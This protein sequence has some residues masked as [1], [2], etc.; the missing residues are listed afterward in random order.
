MNRRQYAIVALFSISLLAV[1]L[2]P[3]SGQQGSGYDP[4]LDYNDDGIINVEDLHALGQAYG[5]SG[6]PLNLPMALEYDSGWLEI[7]DKQGQ[8]TTITPNV[9]NLET[10]T[11]VPC[12]Y[13]KTLLESPVHQRYFGVAGYAYGWIRYYGGTQDG[14]FESVVQTSDFGYALAGYTKSYGPTGDFWLVK[15]DASGNMEWNKTYGWDTE[16][17]DEHAY[18]VI[19]TNDGGYALAGCAL[20]GCFWLVK[21]D[22]SGNMQWNRTYERDY[23][24]IFR[25]LIQTSDGGYILAGWG[26]AWNEDPPGI[27]DDFWLVKTDSYGNME[28]NRTGANG[29]GY[30]VI[31]TNDGGYALAGSKVSASG[32]FWLVKTD[33][34]GNE[35][36]NKTLGGTSAYSVIQTGDGGYA[37][38]GDS[39]GAISLIITDSSGNKQWGGN[40]GSG[41]GYSVV[42]T[43]DRGYALAGYGYTSGSAFILVKTDYKATMQWK[44]TYGGAGMKAHS[45]VQTPDGGY[46]L[47]GE[48]P[49]YGLLIRTDAYGL[50]QDPTQDEGI[51]L[52]IVDYTADT[53]TLYRGKND[54][55]WN[56][57]Q[58]CILV[59]K[60][61]P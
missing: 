61:N 44:Q 31:Q 45:F 51:G 57:V 2:V 32:G 3:L 50:T 38:V 39:A 40:Y 12:I 27:R 19:Q 14:V 41:R 28:W 7:S 1:A 60:E 18:S 49:P 37:L 43:I 29:R 46:V 47:A 4:W 55:Y 56:Y 8:N 17:A 52:S 13:G 54:P 35:Q 22:S 6:T 59:V 48:S 58:V 53:I 11:W 21:T 15:T 20:G 26:G 30:S 34:S 42:Q 33:A 5:S 23:F 24:S 16:F 10:L 36:W 25:S 9:G